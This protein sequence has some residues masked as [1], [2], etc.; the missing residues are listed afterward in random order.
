MMGLL[1]SLQ[2][3]SN[4]NNLKQDK[5]NSIH[6]GSTDHPTPTP[7]LLAV[8][9]GSDPAAGQL[10]EHLL[11]ERLVLVLGARGQ[12]DVAADELVH[13]LTVHLRTNEGQTGLVCKLHRHLATRGR[14]AF[15]SY[16]GQHLLGP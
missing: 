2:H 13:H 15:F 6:C 12:E 11:I 14:T 16:N 4:N 5:T 10:I 7:P 9:A 8:Q 3:S 1:W